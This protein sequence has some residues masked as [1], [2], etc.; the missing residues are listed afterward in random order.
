MALPTW[1]GTLAWYFIKWMGF[2]YLFMALQECWEFVGK[3]QRIDSIRFS[4]F[5]CHMKGN[6]TFVVK[7]GV[8]LTA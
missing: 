4:F 3:L 5:A 1:E 7:C 8:F 6:L 2:L